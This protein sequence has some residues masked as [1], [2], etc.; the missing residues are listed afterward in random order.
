[1]KYDFDEKQ[2]RIEI[3]ITGYLE[4]D[5]DNEQL[6][7]LFNELNIEIKHPLICDYEVE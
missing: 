1:M 4:M 5:L 2:G 3:K 6:E 7:K